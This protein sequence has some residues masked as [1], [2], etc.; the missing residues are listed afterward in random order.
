[1]FKDSESL[2]I[3]LAGKND[4]N[5]TNDPYYY[6]DHPYIDGYE[7]GCPKDT[8]KQDIE[9]GDE[10]LKCGVIRKTFKY[11]ETNRNKAPLT[12]MYE[13]VSLNQLVVTLFIF[14]NF[15]YATK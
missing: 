11:N 7:P 8:N 10:I 3:F 12:L 6:I 9:Y 2:N 14:C 15:K 4:C 1:M 5:V 13:S